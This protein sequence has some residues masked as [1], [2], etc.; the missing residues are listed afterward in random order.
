MLCGVGLAGDLAKFQGVP[1]LGWGFVQ[2]YMEGCLFVYLLRCGCCM[3]CRWCLGDRGTAC[4]RFVAKEEGN[5]WCEWD[6]NMWRLIFG[7][8]RENCGC[9]VHGASQVV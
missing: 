3:G 2:K 5:G 7:G 4:M 9:Q 8:F 1:A 6:Y